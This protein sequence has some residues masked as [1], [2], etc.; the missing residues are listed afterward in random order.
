L[1][2]VPT[3]IVPVIKLPQP[4]GSILIRAGK[5]YIAEPLITVAETAKLLG[6][7]RRT[8]ESMCV[9]GKFR[10]AHKPGGRPRSKWLIER[11]EVMEKKQPPVD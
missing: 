5:P 7:A 8:V 10:T 6:L 2:A 4:D 9:D 1:F 11:A 3:V